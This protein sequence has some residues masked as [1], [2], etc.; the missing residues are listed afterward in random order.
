MVWELKFWMKTFKVMHK[1]PWDLYCFEIWIQAWC[2]VMWAW[3]ASVWA[4]CLWWNEMSICVSSMFMMKWNE[5]LCE[6]KFMNDEIMNCNA[7]HMSCGIK[8]IWRK[9]GVRLVRCRISVKS[10]RELRK[11]WNEIWIKNP[12]W[13][14]CGRAPP[15][16]FYVTLRRASPEEVPVLAEYPREETNPW[17]YV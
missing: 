6:L 1:T 10:K 11:F 5:Y 4:Q 2:V 15:W 8:R 7:L 3:W 14:R 9:F 17:G 12:G 13:H 16:E